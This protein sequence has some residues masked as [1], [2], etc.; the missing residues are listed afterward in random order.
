MA[1]IPLGLTT[2]YTYSLP[3][4]TDCLC[5]HSSFFKFP[6]VYPII[7]KV[8]LKDD[9]NSQITEN[10]YNLCIKIKCIFTCIHQNTEFKKW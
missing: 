4:T 7:P 9:T 8:V 10:N 3:Y 6:I 5:L 2:G 1:I